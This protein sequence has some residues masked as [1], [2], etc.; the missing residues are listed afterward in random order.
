MTLL[1]WVALCA[2]FAGKAIA[3]PTDISPF[4]AEAGG[5]NARVVM[6][7]ERLS[8]G[9]EW[10]SNPERANERFQPA[11]TSKIPHTLIALETGFAGP[12]TVFAWDGKRRTFESWNEDQTLTRAFQRSAVWVY[13]EIARGLGEEVMSEWLAAFDYGNAEIGGAQDLQQYWL[14][15]PLA[16]SADEQLAFLARLAR[17]DL[18]LSA[19]TYA[20]AREIMLAET[21]EDARLYAK[22]GYNLREGQDDLGWYVGWVEDGAEIYVFALNM[23]L[24]G[25]DK[26]PERQRLVRHV[27]D[28]LEIFAA[29]E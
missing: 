2:L 26:A 8:D 9:H 5:E 29:G 25:F 27:L 22:T 13:Q 10:S 4:V 17:E 15:G 20:K 16:I 19:E 1:R 11:S 23:D 21:Q 14:R 6:R 3:Q 12:E 18:P 24:P 7:V 28:R